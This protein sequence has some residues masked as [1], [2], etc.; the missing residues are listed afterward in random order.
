MILGSVGKKKHFEGFLFIY[1]FCFDYSNSLKMSFS[2]GETRILR[3]NENL[4]T[5]FAVRAVVRYDTFF[6]I[7]N[8]RNIRNLVR[9]SKYYSLIKNNVFYTFIDACLLDK[10]KWQQTFYEIDIC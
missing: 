7:H 1:V 4:Y 8:I 6:V 5:S 3:T 2:P 9:L 10:G